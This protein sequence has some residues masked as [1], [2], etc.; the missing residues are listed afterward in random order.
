MLSG[1]YRAFKYS[2]GYLSETL[3]VS[4]AIGLL[5]LAVL[6]R[7]IGVAIWATVALLPLL[8]FSLS[9]WS[10]AGAFTADFASVSPRNWLIVQSVLS[11]LLGLLAT[12]FVRRQRE[13]IR[14]G[15]E[16][17]RLAIQILQE[18]PAVFAVSFSLLAVY[19]VFCLSWLALFTRLF[20]IGHVSAVDETSTLLHRW[21]SDPSSGWLIAYFI[22]VFLWVSAVFAYV[23]RCMVSGVVCEWFFHRH[24]PLRNRHQTSMAWLALRRACSYNFG[25]ICLAALLLSAVQA[26]QMAVR[27]LK[28]M[29]S[30]VTKRDYYITNNN[31]NS[32]GLLTGM[33][34]A[35][36]GLVENVNSYALVYMSYSGVDFMSA[37]RHCDRLFRRNIL[38]PF[39]RGKLLTIN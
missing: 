19:W 12:L 32:G 25:S 36:E 33:L 7:F 35:V 13:N 16:I 21:V 6:R 4:L 17:V 27:S 9:A 38:I 2:A 24:D 1:L 8:L 26:I 39:L 15:I 34:A 18:N 10:M 5:W 20:L 37:L 11:A 28:R 30:A 31:N 29:L 22:C 23:E 3:A 14:R